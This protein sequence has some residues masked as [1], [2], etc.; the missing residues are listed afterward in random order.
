MYGIMP[1]ELFFVVAVVFSGSWDFLYSRR[2]Q[3]FISELNNAYFAR[4]L[5]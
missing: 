1:Q 5:F 2:K 4:H 3:L